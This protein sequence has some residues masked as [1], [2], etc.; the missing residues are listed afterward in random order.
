MEGRFRLPSSSTIA[1]DHDRS[2]MG[3]TAHC[4]YSLMYP[5]ALSAMYP[6]VSAASYVL[7][8]WA[9]DKGGFRGLPQG[10]SRVWSKGAIQHEKLPSSLFC[11][12]NGDSGLRRLAR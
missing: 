1:A 9:F 7:R 6:S 11:G 8:G 4:A 12:G 2:V 10:I 3:S 5:I